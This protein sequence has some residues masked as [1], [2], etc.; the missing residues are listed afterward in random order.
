MERPTEGIRYSYVKHC[1]VTAACH[2]PL[3]KPEATKH[4]GKEFEQG[5]KEPMGF[6]SP[7]CLHH[8]RSR[9]TYWGR[10]ASNP[11]RGHLDLDCNGLLKTLK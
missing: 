1:L 6:P 10:R 7:C 9:L 4:S 3:E 5:E 8:L 2:L 11:M